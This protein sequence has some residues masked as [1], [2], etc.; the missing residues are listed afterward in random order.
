M[1]TVI[2]LR[3]YREIR[4]IFVYIAQDNPSAAERVRDR[5]YE[6][7]DHLARHPKSGHLTMQP[8][9]RSFPLGNY[10]YVVLYRYRERRRE[11]RI[12]HVLHGARRRPALRED[13]AEFR[14][15]A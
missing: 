7:I 9:V 3:A 10:P 2:S 15:Q 4:E 1:T 6:V 5:V 8:G 12:L 11:V 13:A 14:W